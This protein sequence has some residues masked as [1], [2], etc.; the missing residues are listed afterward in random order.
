MNSL[1]SS[2]N[3]NNKGILDVWYFG[4]AWFVHRGGPLTYPVLGPFDSQLDAQRA[5]DHYQDD[6]EN[7]PFAAIPMSFTV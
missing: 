5:L 3:D 7:D 4:G 6:L 2:C 1:E